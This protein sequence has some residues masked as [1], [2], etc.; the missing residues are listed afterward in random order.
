MKTNKLSIVALI[1][2]SATMLFSCKKDEN[3]P[4]SSSEA[5]KGTISGYAYA[6]LDQTAAGYEF[7]PNGTNVIASTF[8]S[9]KQ[10][11][12]TGTITDGKYSISIPVGRNSNNFSI[13]FDSFSATQTLA[14][15]SKKVKSYSPNAIGNV[16]LSANQ[17]VA[18]NATYNVTDN[19][20]GNLNQTISYNGSAKY[21]SDESDALTAYKDIKNVPD[22]TKVYLRNN[23]TNE[24]YVT[25]TTNG[26]YKFLISTPAGESFNGTIWFD[27][28][29]ASLKTA[30]T[31]DDKIWSA[32][33]LNAN[34]NAGSIKILESTF[35]HN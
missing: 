31:L 13:S 4:T 16:V 27:E 33:S 28:F 29:K 10:F 30:T 7:A 8:I 6:D 19:N 32:G 26:E 3:K 5:E 9:G 18:Q 14:D 1:G 25:T 21:D 2:L 17:N 35:G 24:K 34:A 22:G 20:P 11:N 12:Y 15:G 23:N